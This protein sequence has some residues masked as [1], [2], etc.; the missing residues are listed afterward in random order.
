[1]LVRAL[2][3]REHTL[4]ESAHRLSIAEL[5]SWYS[6]HGASA[7]VELVPL[8]CP[9]LRDRS[10]LV[11]PFLRRRV[12]STKDTPEGLVSLRGAVRIA[13]AVYVSS[14]EARRHNCEFTCLALAW[15]L[16]KS[17]KRVREAR[18]TEQSPLRGRSGAT[19][20]YVYFRSSAVDLKWVRVHL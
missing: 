2:F 12:Q 10:P 17:A 16:F 14:L 13:V 18:A 4:P 1:L 8:R 20:G 15:A 5:S 11:L 3:A 6:E 19:M 7:L 9:N